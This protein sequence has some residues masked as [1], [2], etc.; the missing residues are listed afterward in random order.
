VSDYLSFVDKSEDG[1][2]GADADHQRRLWAQREFLWTACG[3]MGGA[4]ILTGLVTLAFSLLNLIDRL[5]FWFFLL[6]I[7]GE[8]GLAALLWLLQKKVQLGKILSVA[9]FFVFAVATGISLYII[10]FFFD[11]HLRLLAVG[12][13]FALMSAYGFSSKPKHGKVTWIILTGLLA[14]LLGSVVNLFWAGGMVG[15]VATYV[16]V[17]LFILLLAAD[18]KEIF[19]VS[20]RGHRPVHAAFKM[21]LDMIIGI[22]RFVAEII[23][24]IVKGASD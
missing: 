13:A 2:A 3:W 10:F 21:Y 4:L 7:L 8:C 15:W 20:E 19:R 9:V 11:L 5:G 18:Y 22:F 1:R 24:G 14:A 6:V 12:A 17:G 16:V 23:G